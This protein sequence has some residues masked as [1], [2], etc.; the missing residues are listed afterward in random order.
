MG[1]LSIGW[2]T[3]GR[4]GRVGSCTFDYS[5]LPVLVSSSF[6]KMFRYPVRFSGDET[7][8]DEDDNNAVVVPNKR[9]RK[10]EGGVA[11]VDNNGGEEKEDH[12][13]ELDLNRQ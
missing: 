4:R 13:F 1:S 8:K 3:K 7:G 12:V 9:M 11:D 5:P 2:T 10:E 6:E